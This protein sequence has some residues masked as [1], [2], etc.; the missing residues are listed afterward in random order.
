MERILRDE[1]F[2]EKILCNLIVLWICV[3]F[4]EVFEMC[5]FRD[6]LLLILIEFVDRL[7]LFEFFF[8]VLFV[9]GLIFDND[10]D[11]IV[12]ICIFL[13]LIVDCV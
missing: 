13:L 4:L 3:I 7:D 8:F 2:I 6:F 1:V 9:D 11:F 5:V 10:D 12:I